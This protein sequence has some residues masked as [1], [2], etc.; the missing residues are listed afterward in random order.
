MKKYITVIIVSLLTFLSCEKDDI[1]IETTTPSLVI[2][3]YNND[4]QTDVKNVLLDSVWALDKNG[5]EQYKSVSIDSIVIPLNLNENSTTY[6]IENNSSKDT[7]KFIYDR[8]DVFVSRSCGYKTIFENL[9]ID[10]NSINWIKNININNTI[11]END[12]AAHISIF[13]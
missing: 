9:Q 4:I 1:C 13:H 8:K 6:I 10:N 3:F 7:I 11:I 12:T 2:R 5:I